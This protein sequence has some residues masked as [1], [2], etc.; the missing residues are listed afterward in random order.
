MMLILCHRINVTKPFKISLIQ[1]FRGQVFMG[2]DFIGIDSLRERER[3]RGGGG[4]GGGESCRLLPL[5]TFIIV[6]FS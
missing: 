4:G 6:A 5:L 2:V 1:D 3:E